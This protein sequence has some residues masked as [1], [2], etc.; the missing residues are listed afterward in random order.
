MTKKTLSD[1]IE[2]VGFS[3]EVEFK[4]LQG[5]K[6]MF[7]ATKGEEGLKVKDVKEKVQNA[8]RRTKEV[9]SMEWSKGMEHVLNEL[10]EIF[11]DE[12]GEEILK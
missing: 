8:Q 6:K 5:D 1:K 9:I 2:V 12:F 11:K 10:E 4:N 3:T 7:P